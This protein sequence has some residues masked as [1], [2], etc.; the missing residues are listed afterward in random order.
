MVFGENDLRF[1]NSAFR[2]AE[3]A[4]EKDEIPVGAVIVKDGII[5]AKGYNQVEMLID[6]TAHAEIIAITAACNN[7]N[8]KN[9]SGCD[10]YVTLEPCAMCAGAII[11]SKISRVFFGAQEPK[12]GACT[13]LYSLLSDGKNIHKAQVYHGLMEDRVVALMKHFFF[14]KRANGTIN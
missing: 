9:L 14:N 13:S 7:L 5:I 10:L 3:Y 8:S 12:T 11:N 2:E 1:M 6:P 4:M